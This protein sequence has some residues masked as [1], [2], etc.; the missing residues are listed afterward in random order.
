MAKTFEVPDT[1]NHRVRSLFETMKKRTAVMGILNVT[2]DSFSDGGAYPDSETAVRRAIQMVSEGADII[3]IGGESTRPGAEPV[4]VEKEISRVLPV[5][6]GLRS[7]SD[8]PISIDTYKAE[9]AAAA[10]DAG[11]DVVNDISGLNFDP[12]M[13]SLLAEKKA[14]AVFMHIKGSPRDMQKN[15]R[16][17]DLVG[18]ISSYLLESIHIATS[19]GLPKELIIVD[20]GFGF[21]KNPE[22]N[23]E[24]VRRLG[25]FCKLG[26]PVMIG[27]SRKSTI[28]VIL[29]GLPP[30]ERIEGTAAIVAISIANGADIVRVH[31]VKQMARVA[32]VADACI[33]LG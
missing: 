9:T 21:G 11:A 16:Y 18:E 30:E 28:G 14:A 32:K 24:I 7:K 2:P 23:L 12:D 25:D 20:P 17:E 3:D 33:G 19:A 8:I 1:H 15:P 13:P 4:P 29:G 27:P 22:H 10:L 26:H 31:D 5:I 6:S